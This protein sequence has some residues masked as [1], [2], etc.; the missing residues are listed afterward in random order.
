MH[1]WGKAGAVPLLAMGCRWSLELEGLAEEE[2]GP[3]LRRWERCAALSKDPRA[4][5]LDETVEPVRFAAAAAAAAEADP[6]GGGVTVVPDDPADLPYDLSRALTRR[7]IARLRGR[8]PLLL[9]AAA[10]AD[11]GRALVLVAPSGG[12]KSTAALSLGQVLGYVTDESVVVA[13]DGRLA[14]YPKAPSLLGQADDPTSKVEPAPDD[15][16]LGPTPGEVTLTALLA[17][18]RDGTSPPAVVPVPLVDHLVALVPETSS[19]W[20]VEGGLDRLAR[21]AV[22]GGAPAELRYAEVESC[23]EVVR[24]HLAAARPAHPG[25]THHP[26]D[27]G[28]AW[29]EEQPPPPSDVRPDAAVERAPWSDALED[30]GVLL[31]LQGSRVTRVGGLAVPVWVAC[32]TPRTTDEIARDLVSS[33]GEHPDAAALVRQGVTSLVTAGLLRPA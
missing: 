18:R 21:A 33:L 12:G 3:M 7:G 10:L 15:L 28:S 4:L 29:R 9:H 17:L 6:A 19:L 23:T 2:R 11:G 25:W 8:G 20:L 32:E 31:V 13:E 26:P 14:P 22:A 5:V 16:G 27:A 1:G 30:E 24:D